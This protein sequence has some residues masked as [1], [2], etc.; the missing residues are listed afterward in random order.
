MVKI[1]ARRT[2]T[3]E[4]NTKVFIVSLYEKTNKIIENHFKS[5]GYQVSNKISK[6]VKIYSGN[7]I[8]C[9]L[10]FSRYI[11][12]NNKFI[13]VNCNINEWIS[14]VQNN[15]VKKNKHTR[16]MF[17]DYSFKAL[18]KVF[19]DHQL[20]TIKYVPQQNMLFMNVGDDQ[21]TLIDFLKYRS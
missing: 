15:H 6:N 16:E 18:K 1:N 3:P 14:H 5:W 21:Q 19:I 7:P 17:N 20:E 8:F 12:K 13:Y 11:T 10:F 4:I 9:P 2:K